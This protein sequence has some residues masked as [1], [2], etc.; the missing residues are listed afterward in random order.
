MVLFH[1]FP[2]M[3]LYTYRGR[4][5]IDRMFFMLVNQLFSPS[6]WSNSHVPA[7]VHVCTS[8]GRGENNRTLHKDTL[9]RI[10]LTRRYTAYP[11]TLHTGVRVRSIF[12]KI[13][14]AK[15]ILCFLDAS[16]HLYKRP[17]PSVRWLVGWSVRPSVGYAFVKIDEKWPF[18]DSK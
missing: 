13:T 9:P 17:C 15:Q 3:T 11:C 5:Y 4:S 10:S 1:S 6:A 2:L 18:M 7:Y 12:A 8:L 14:D 16:S